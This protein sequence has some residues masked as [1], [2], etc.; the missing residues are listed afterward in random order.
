[1]KI[2]IVMGFFLPVPP[3]AGGA[4]EKTWHR[5]AHEFVARGHEVAIFSRRWP[6]FA[7]DETVE[8]IKYVRLRGYA[9]TP[10]LWQN[11]LLDFFWSRRVSRALPTADIVIVNCIS[12]PIWLGARRPEAGRVVVLAGRVPKG[13]FRFYRHLSR[14]LAPSTDV[15]KKIVAENPKL[16]DIVRVTGYPIAWSELEKKSPPHDS[17]LPLTIGYVGRLHREKGLDL[18]RAAL[19]L[20]AAE[21]VP[22]WRVILCGPSDVARGGSGPDYAKKLADEFRTFLPPARFSLLDPIFETEALKKIYHQIDIFCY[23][24]LATRGET[25]G[26]AAADAMAASAAPVVSRLACFSDLITHRENGLVFDHATSDAPA[27]LASALREL[28]TDSA[29]RRK[30]AVA[31][32]ETTRRYDFPIFADALLGDFTSLTTAST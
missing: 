30:L 25:F 24:S 8:G 20:L 31:A 10:R 11:L 1:M 17:D 18:L 32:R 3:V 13:Q 16:A 12:L 21:K 14:V 2:S 28:L 6:D 5:L 19:R 27:Q 4:T 15:Q 26:V 9:H 23:P 7:N 29:L 22:P